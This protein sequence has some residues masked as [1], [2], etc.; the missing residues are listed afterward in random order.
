MCTPSCTYI[1]QPWSTRLCHAQVVPLPLT[2][3]DSC[4]KVVLEIRGVKSD[5]N[6][7]PVRLTFCC[8]F[9]SDDSILEVEQD[10]RFVKR[11]ERLRVVS[12]GSEPYRAR[13]VEV[14]SGGGGC[15][16]NAR[17]LDVQSFGNILWIP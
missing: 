3:L 12:A 17:V 11:Y 10:H 4:W 7:V 9:T 15:G 5:K 16:C 2:L 14:E 1:Y 8:K 13:C 6:R